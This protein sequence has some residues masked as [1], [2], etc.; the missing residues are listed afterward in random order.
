MQFAEIIARHK[1]TKLSQTF[2]H[3]LDKNA[4]QKTIHKAISI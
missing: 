2:N 4:T 1:T 3:I